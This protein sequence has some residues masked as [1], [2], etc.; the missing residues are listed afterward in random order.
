MLMRVDDMFCRCRTRRNVNTTSNP[1]LTIQE[2]V[3]DPKGKKRAVPEPSSD[4][5]NTA[6]TSSKRSRTTSYSLRSQTS[7]NQSPDMPKKTR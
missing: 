2:P 7:T 6:S 5:E 4:E 3:K 1:P